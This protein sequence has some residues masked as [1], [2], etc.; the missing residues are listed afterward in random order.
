MINMSVIKAFLVSP[1][2]W[3]RV[4]VA[5]IFFIG[6]AYAFLHHIPAWNVPN[7]TGGG[8]GVEDSFS[9]ARW[10]LVPSVLGTLSGAAVSVVIL[11]VLLLLTLLFGRVY[12]SFICPLGILQDI[13]FR[14]RR[15]LARRFLKFSRPV[16][17]MRYGVL[18][19]LA[20]CCV[21]GLAGLS[22]NW[23]D[24][25]SIFGRIMYVLAWPAAIW[26]NNL[27]AADSSSA[28]LVQMDYFPAAFP[29]L[30]A[31][32]GMLGLV[33]VMSAWKGRLYC[34]TVCPVGTFL[35]LLS[36]ISLFRLGFDPA[37]CKKC[38][39]CVKSCKAQC[40]NLK[41]YK[42]DS[43]RCVACYDCVRSCSE[44]GIRYR[45]FTRVR[46]QIPAQKKKV[47]PASAPSSSAAVPSIAGSSRRQFLE[48]TA[49]G[50]AA[51][52][53]SGCRG[54]AARKLDPTQCVLP[55]GAGS[56]ER[57]LDICTGCQMC[58]ANCPTHVLQPSYLQLGL[59][60]FMKPRMD[61]A[62]KY[63]LYDCHRCAE[64]CPTGAIRRMPV[65]AERDTEGIT[66]DTT[67]IAVARFYV[68]RC[69]VAREDMDCGACTEHCPT[70]A[71]YTVPYI[72]R[73]G[74]EHRL[75]R[76]DPSLC[77]GCG[78]CE[79]ACPVT[80]ERPEERERRNSCDLCEEKCEFG[81]RREMPP[82]ALVVRAVNPQQ[83]AVKKFED[84]AVDPVGDA[85]FP[86]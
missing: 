80:A 35:G 16:P 64:V 21:M 39:K 4:T 33:A 18:A 29:V 72:G 77:I 45:W 68:C 15:W 14:I 20:A 38:G 43:S 13:V 57:F 55:P 17:W 84:K 66:K 28:D 25:Y 67:R 12:C 58:V 83:K 2:K 24:P 53:F 60:G 3:L 51:A 22:L 5:V 34:N 46:Q 82:R 19:L 74:Q 79:H 32:A 61:F 78:A 52:A 69:L 56:L 70:K 41:E 42:I 81:R 27:L 54:D 30:L 73:D 10:Q 86:F 11:G 7:M 63:C 65:T 48:A 76:L 62:T 40:L 1:L 26:S 36:R 23:L 44:G 8:E 50:L 37:S 85:D 9:L 59:K 6:I 75:P 49:V 31:S 47:P 71:L